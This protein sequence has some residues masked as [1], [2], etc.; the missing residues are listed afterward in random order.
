MG[1]LN[2]LFE[3]RSRETVAA[4]DPSLA[5]LLGMGGPHAVSPERAAGHAVAHRCIQ[6]IAENLAAVPLRVHRRGEDGGRTVAADLPLH[7]VLHDAPN[8]QMTAF[9]AREL[10]VAS[11]LIHGNAFARVEWNG[12]G[13]VVEL[14]PLIPSTVAV[15]RVR[16]GALRYRVSEPDG[17]VRVLLADEVL[18]L[19]YRTRADG[20]MGLSPLAIAR[21]HIALAA[22]QL[23]QAGSHARN[24][25][26]PTGA[27][28][29]PQAL[30]KESADRLR[31]GMRNRADPT[32]ALVL[33]GGV[34]W[35]SFAF[36]ARDAEFLESRKLSNL[37]VCRVFG[38]PPSVAGILDDATYSNIGEE[39][40]ALVVRCLAPMARRIEQAMN[41]AL[42]PMSARRTL[43]VE[44]DLAGLLRGDLGARYAAYATGRQAGFLSVNEIRAFENMPTVDGGDRFLE[45]VNMVEASE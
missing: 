44:H 13:Q 24:G 4:S 25:F 2:R 10:L 18:H 30:G 43:F 11:L 20:I 27:L 1:I 9:E 6:T 8:G 23:D 12:R 31:N 26:R 15:E 38:V 40:R 19:R 17:G 29:F 34:K 37:D 22:A 16:G 5:H 41:A 7:G 35:E 39:S 36:S 33:D 14:H 3:R 42:L 45:P 32:E 21:E 28:V